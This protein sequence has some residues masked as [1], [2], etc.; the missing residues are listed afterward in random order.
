MKIVV[1][2]GGGLVGSRVVARLT[3]LGHRAV[4]ASPRTGVNALTGEGLAAALDGAAVLVDVAN[5]PSFEDDA[6]L[7]FFETS[8]ANLLAAEAAAGVGHHVALS[9][10]GTG[11]LTASGYFRA[12]TAQERLVSA[13]PIPYSVVRATQF[14]EFVGAIADAGTADGTVRV[15]PVFIQPIAADDVAAAVSGTALGTPANGVVEIAGPERFRL[16]DL[17]RTVLS[18]HDDHRPVVADPRARYFGASLD[19]GTLTPG[20]DAAL[21]GTHLVDW[22]KER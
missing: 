20:D 9:V 12:K 11:R 14:F 8:T 2:G 22:L 7:R 21:G 17:V 5:S 6:V 19:D 3:G 13:G 4:A 1:I 15:P 10:V 18:A 16:D